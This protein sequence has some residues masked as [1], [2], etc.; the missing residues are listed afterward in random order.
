MTGFT[1]YALR[2]PVTA[3]C[4]PGNV[5]HAQTLKCDQCSH[6]YLLEYE[7]LCTDPHDLAAMLIAARRVIKGEHFSHAQHGKL[8]CELLMRPAA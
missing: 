8:K 7:A 4:E 2:E 5:R 6:T 3:E 1:A